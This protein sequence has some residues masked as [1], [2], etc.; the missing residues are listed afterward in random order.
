MRW[1][2]RSAALLIVVVSAVA[3]AAQAAGGWYDAGV[4]DVD[5][6][7]LTAEHRCGWPTPVPCEEKAVAAA[8]TALRQSEPDADVVGASMAGYPSQRTRPGEIDFAFA[9]LQTP[10]FVIL[11]LGDGTRRTIGLM[12]GALRHVGDRVEEGCVLN[13]MDMFRVG[14][15]TGR[16]D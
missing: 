11:D 16:P 12:C 2:L 8:V 15:A 13:D 7:W 6:Y 9:G 1:L 10:R 3:C 5:G 14:A 4:H